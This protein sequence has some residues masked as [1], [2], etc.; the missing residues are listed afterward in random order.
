M[1]AAVTGN[2]ETKAH[3]AHLVYLVNKALKQD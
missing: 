1:Q 2:E 3:R